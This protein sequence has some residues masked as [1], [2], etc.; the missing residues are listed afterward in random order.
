MKDVNWGKI[1]IIQMQDAFNVLMWLNGTEQGPNW[2]CHLSKWD[3][4]AVTP[5]RKATVAT[6]FTYLEKQKVRRCRYFWKPWRWFLSPRRAQRNPPLRNVPRWWWVSRRP[7]PPDGRPPG[8][9]AKKKNHLY[10]S[11]PPSLR[12]QGM[13]RWLTSPII[14]FHTLFTFLPCFPL[15]T[16]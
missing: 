9:K 10:L 14:P 12:A 15:V 5:H 1:G 4:R 11:F 7:W 3:G 6:K 2:S 8:R 13:K 16:R